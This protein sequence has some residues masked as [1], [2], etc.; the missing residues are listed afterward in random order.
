MILSALAAHRD[1][2]DSRAFLRVSAAGVRS[3]APNPNSSAL[4]PMSQ[5]GLKVASRPPSNPQMKHRVVIASYAALTA[6]LFQRPLT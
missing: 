3:H 4:S 1:R 5:A 6:I 2:L